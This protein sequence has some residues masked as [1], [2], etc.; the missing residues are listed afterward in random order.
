MKRCLY[1]NE[2]KDSMEDDGIET[3]FV[4]FDGEEYIKCIPRHLSSF[5][6]GSF[7]QK[8]DEELIK[9]N[10]EIKKNK[11]ESK[12]K[13]KY[14]TLKFGAVFI[15]LVSAFFLFRCIKR[16]KVENINSFYFNDN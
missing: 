15:I 14:G 7:D 10:N 3:Q 6:I 9:E 8:G 16:K 12:N 2:E 4:E 11:K 13:L 5:T 1:Y